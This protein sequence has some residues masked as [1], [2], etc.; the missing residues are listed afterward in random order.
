[1]TSFAGLFA[2]RERSPSLPHTGRTVSRDRLI[3]RSINST[4]GNA[5]WTPLQRLVAATALTRRR[6]RWSKAGIYC[7]PPR[8]M[9]SIPLPATIPRRKAAKRARAIC[10]SNIVIILVKDWSCSEVYRSV[11]VTVRGRSSR[12]SPRLIS[13]ALQHRF[14]SADR[15]PDYRLRRH[16]RLV[17]QV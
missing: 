9:I 3:V 6:T 15:H 11:I 10:A 17:F 12:A 14:G 5:P 8:T 16:C 4:A 2:S 7:R 13:L 1:L